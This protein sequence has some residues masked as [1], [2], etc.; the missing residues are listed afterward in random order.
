MKLFLLSLLVCLAHS[1][2]VDPKFATNLTVFHVNEFN[3]S[4]IANMDTGDNAGDAFFS[5]RSIYLPIECTNKS[6][7]SSHHFAGDCD[8]PEVVGSKL[9]VTE[10]VV[11]VD[12]RFG[13]YSECNVC[14]NSTVPF[15]TNVSC[16]DGDY[17]CV[18]GDFSNLT[19]NCPP[20]VGVES[21][22]SVF[23]R[24]PIQP[25]SPNWSWWTRNLVDRLDGRWYSTPSSGECDDT[26]KPCYWSLVQTNRRIL[27]SCQD[28][29]IFSQVEKRNPSCWNGCPQ[30]TN[31]TSDC[32]IGCFFSTLLGPDSDHRNSTVGMTAA[33]IVGIWT[34]PV[35]N[36]ETK[37]G[38]PDI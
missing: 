6:T 2:H 26:D 8:N 3:Y 29:Y 15:T 9:T 10:V 37:G 11:T 31:T 13:N 27:K 1:G 16:I 17:V 14:V 28:A 36:D 4:G 33:E 7:N 34:Y 18:C 21:P 35:V 24:F 5:L 32:Y 23:N 25:D 19:T 30:P 22:A 20:T 38:C 12:S